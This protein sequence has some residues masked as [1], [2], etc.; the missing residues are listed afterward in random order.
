MSAVSPNECI[1]S[2]QTKLDGV[3]DEYRVSVDMLTHNAL[4][5]HRDCETQRGSGKVIKIKVS[6]ANEQSNY[7]LTVSDTLA[8]SS[9]S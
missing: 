7:K 6:R 9:S 8:D 4:Q 5:M 3:N 1:Q 2:V